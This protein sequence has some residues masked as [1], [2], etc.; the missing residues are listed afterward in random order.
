MQTLI[1]MAAKLTVYEIENVTPNEKQREMFL[2]C[3]SLPVEFDHT[4][5]VITV[6]HSKIKVLR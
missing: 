1:K 2:S 5:S 6:L 4:G 3:P